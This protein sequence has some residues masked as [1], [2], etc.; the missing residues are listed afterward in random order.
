MEIALIALSIIS[1]SFFIGLVSAMGKIKNISEGF[2]QLFIT[3]NTLREAVDIK[4]S[5]PKSDE[6]IHKENFIKFLSDSREWAFGYI[7]E[8]QSGL[9][10]FIEEVE[11]EIEYYNQYG[12]VVEGMI[13]PHDKALKKISKEFEDLKKLLPEDTSDRR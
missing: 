10:K 2:S 7:E 11:P 3:Y 5:F 6:D 4:D 13:A 8:V 1:V 12:I 9:K